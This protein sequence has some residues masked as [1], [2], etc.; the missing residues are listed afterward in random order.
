MAHPTDDQPGLHTYQT[1]RGG[2]IQEVL[3]ASGNNALKCADVGL[4][5]YK[6]ICLNTRY[7]K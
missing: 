1:H 6:L 5:C 7:L 2:A 3:M 4:F